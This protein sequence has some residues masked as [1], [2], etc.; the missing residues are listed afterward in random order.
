MSDTKQAIDNIMNIV[1]KG[2][3]AF[4]FPYRMGETL[5]TLKAAK[6]EMEQR[7]LIGGDNYS[8]RLGMCLNAQDG[9]DKA[10][11]SLG[12]GL[13]KELL[14][15][16]PKKTLKGVSQI[17]IL[18]DGLKDMGNNIEGD[19]WG[20]TNPDKSCRIWLNDLDLSSNTWK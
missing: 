20:L 17:K 7:N 1:F 2:S 18:K 5:G 4:N 15:D 9:I 12:F 13:A 6:D 14:V 19:V 10:I 11:Y 3:E 8:H 16:Y